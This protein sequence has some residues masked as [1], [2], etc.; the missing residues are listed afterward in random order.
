MLGAM[1]RTACCAGIAAALMLVAQGAGAGARLPCGSV[2]VFSDAAVNV[3]V[4]PYRYEA[5][6]EFDAHSASS[7][8]AALIQQESL[9]AMLK[10]GSIGATELVEE[11]GRFCDVREALSAVAAGSGNGKL[12]PGHGL[13]VIWGRIYEDK[14]EV[15]IQSYIRFLRRDVRE[16]FSVELAREGGPAL[17]LVAPLPAQAVALAPRRLTQ[18]DLKAIEKAAAAALVLRNEPRDSA[19]GRPMYD[20]PI[21]PLAYSVEA[22]QGD[23][24]RVRSFFDPSKTGWVRARTDEEGW[25]LRRFLPELGN[26]D[27]VAGYLRLRSSDRAGPV[28]DPKRVYGWV[29]RAFEGYEKAVGKDAAPEAAGLARAMAGLLLWTQPVLAGDQGRAEA[30]KLFREALEFIPASPEARV[31]SAVTAPLSGEPR[32]LDKVALASLDRG[33]LAAAALDARNR[34]ALENLERLYGYASESPSISPYG[35]EELRGRLA[36]VKAAQGGPR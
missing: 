6:R 11:R 36:A 15:Y 12:L 23:W 24:M 1:T 3:L 27:G 21:E 19:P 7:R 35:I 9:F 33:L 4:L 22:A 18:N 34:A 28:A 17:R 32:V 10:Y 30:A 25:A 31:L 29:R 20:S 8:L 5:P 14:S 13:A 26:L 2:Q 16:A